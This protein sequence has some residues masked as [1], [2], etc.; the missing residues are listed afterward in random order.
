MEVHGCQR[1]VVRNVAEKDILQ[2]IVEEHRTRNVSIAV[3]QVTG[4]NIVMLRKIMQRRKIQVVEVVV[5]PEDHIIV[6]EDTATTVC[7]KPERRII[8]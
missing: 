1:Q 2:T 6:E 4:K 3:K 8:G 5:D 7:E